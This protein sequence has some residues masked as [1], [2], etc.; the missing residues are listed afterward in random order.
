MPDDERV[1]PPVRRRGRRPLFHRRGHAHQECVQPAVPHAQRRHHHRA[2]PPAL[3][4]QHLLWQQHRD[5]QPAPP[6]LWHDS[7]QLCARRGGEEHHQE[8]H[9]RQQWACVVWRHRHRMADARP[10]PDGPHRH[11]LAAGHQQELSLVGLHGRA[12]RH[13]HLGTLE[14]RHGQSEDEQRQPCDAPGR[15]RLV[16]L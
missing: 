3:P 2:R 15:P 1:C 7:R 16:A 13:H 4:R 9:H 11:R 12:W 5:R 10:H 6:R 14:R 8:H